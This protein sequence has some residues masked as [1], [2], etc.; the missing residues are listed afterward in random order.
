MTNQLDRLNAALSD[1]Y[2][3]ER[4]IGSGGM[5]RVYLGLDL[6]HRRNVAIK[7]LRPDLAATLGSERFL[8]EIE[9]AAQLNHPH[10]LPLLDSGDAD[11]FLYYA[12][13]HV[14]GG[15]LRQ[16]LLSTE[17]LPSD[18]VAHVAQEVARALE[19]AHRLGVIHRDIKP[20][21]ILFSEGLAVVADFGIARVLGSISSEAL[22]RSGFPLG[23]PG[24]MSP[25]QAAGN[26][27]LDARTDVC[28]LA[29][30]VY[31]ML[32]G[33]TPG[34]WSTPDEVRV[35]RFL[36]L[37]HGHR[38]LLDQLPG[39]VEQVL[40]KGLAIRPTHRP[41]SPVVFADALA[42]VLE[43]GAK[44]GNSEVREILGRAAQLEVHAPTEEGVLS[45]GGVEQVAAEV[46]IPPVVVREAAQALERPE[47]GIARGGYL[48]V[49]GRIDLESTVAAP[50]SQRAY[51][52]MLEEIRQTIGE[53]G[54]VNETFDQSFYWEGRLPTSSARKVQVTVIPT[55][56][57]CKVRIVEHRGEDMA[58]PIASII[59]G[60]F[61]S[62][63]ACVAVARDVDSLLAGWLTGTVIWFGQYGVVRVLYHRFLKKRFGI[64]QGLLKRL[65]RHA[66]GAEV[67]AQSAGDDPALEARESTDSS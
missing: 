60:G 30:V 9:V 10:I 67:A 55:G 29:C 62:I 7:V 58:V 12:M 63:L 49:T 16:R 20:E 38:G 41:A 57:R 31:E 35:G 4:E 5:A 51:S 66:G 37:S 3:I 59:A 1:R 17:T 24:Y 33:E 61:V 21:N 65:S 14:S 19:Y 50:T 27:T 11:G 47:T 26:T 39:R 8:R 44:L 56:E 40:V 18:K 2:T 54:R 28:S 46:G 23:T 13:P 6:K 52:A 22:T 53:A 45:L 32:I 15:S 25:E 48:G 43:P 36:E 64:L 42:A 34:V